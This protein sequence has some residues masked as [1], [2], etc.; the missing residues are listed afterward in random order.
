M[1]ATSFDLPC[2]MDI[3]VTCVLLDLTQ[4]ALYDESVA[5]FKSKEDEIRPYFTI[6]EKGTEYP[7][8]I[9]YMV[10]EFSPPR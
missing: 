5:A 9:K 10:W 2:K 3:N 7:V 4:L 1:R 8:N 6:T